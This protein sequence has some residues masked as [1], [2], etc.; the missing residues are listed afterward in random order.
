MCNSIIVRHASRES[1]ETHW[2]ATDMLV[3]ALWH[4]PFRAIRSPRALYYVSRASSLVVVPGT[5]P[6]FA[7]GASVQLKT[8]DRD[9]RR[10][11]LQPVP[12]CS[13]S[14][15]LAFAVPL[16]HSASRCPPISRQADFAPVGPWTFLNSTQ[17]SNPLPPN[18]PKVTPRAPSAAAAAPL[19]HTVYQDLSHTN[20]LPLLLQPSTLAA[21]T[22]N[23]STTHTHS[24]LLSLPHSLVRHCRRL[25]ASPNP[26]TSP[27]EHHL[28]PASTA[29]TDFRLRRAHPD[30][31]FPRLSPHF[32]SRDPGETLCRRPSASCACRWKRLIVQSTTSRT[33]CPLP[34][35]ARCA[36]DDAVGRAELPA[37]TNNH[38]GGCSSNSFPQSSINLVIL[39]RSWPIHHLHVRPHVRAF[40]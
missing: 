26:P 11:S 2:H 15:A 40:A 38:Y 10:R 30:S 22:T 12:H 37:S 7:D 1:S 16:A 5:Q 36:L 28:L 21:E 31:R 29:H 34:G 3:A 35:R 27:P 39:C 17:P 6:L 13:R 33:A 19:L 23:C 25:F 20:S 4:S 24:L 18:H 14:L 32:P 8:T 9:R